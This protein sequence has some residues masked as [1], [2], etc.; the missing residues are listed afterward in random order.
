MTDVKITMESEVC[1]NDDV[2]FSEVEGE[3]VIMN[4]ETGKYFSFS[5]VTS[6]IWEL[7]EE[8]IKISE[9]CSALLTRYKVTAEQCENETLDILNT[10][11]RE[12]I[13]NVA[14]K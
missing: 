10:L 3:T 14:A 4:I 13:I 5:L 9:I 12:N 11:L 1:R 2:V 7:M 6:H 8:P